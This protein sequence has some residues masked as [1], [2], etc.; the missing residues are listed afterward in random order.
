MTICNYNAPRK[1]HATYNFSF[2]ETY[3]SGSRGWSTGT[4]SRQLTIVSGQSNST[5]LGSWQPPSGS[6]MQHVNIGVGGTLLSY[7]TKGTPQYNLLFNNIVKLNPEVIWIYWVQ[8]EADAENGSSHY[9]THQTRFAQFVSDLDTDLLAAGITVVPYWI[10]GQLHTNCFNGSHSDGVTAIR[11]SYSN[12]VA[13]NPDRSTLLS[14]D[15]F[16]LA[17]DN[18]HYQIGDV[19]ARRTRFDDAR[20]ILCPV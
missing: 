2:S 8:G 12:F 3:S 15:D 17:A 20:L 16:T 11:T 13:N 7:H 9:S 18:V 4:Y 14:F 10:I 5:N 1:G 6:I 19:A